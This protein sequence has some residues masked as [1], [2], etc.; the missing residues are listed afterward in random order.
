LLLLGK[1]S[2]PFSHVARRHFSYI[3]EVEREYMKQKW[4]ILLLVVVAGCQSV[5]PE[6]PSVEA[7]LVA[8]PIPVLIAQLQ[9]LNNALANGLSVQSVESLDAATLVVEDFDGAP[10]VNVTVTAPV[11]I[12]EL[13]AF[14]ATLSGNEWNEEDASSPWTITPFAT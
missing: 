9:A 6:E 3:F 8:E 12:S 2:I 10:F 13:W 7:S 14:A 11:P 5:S 4:L 1:V